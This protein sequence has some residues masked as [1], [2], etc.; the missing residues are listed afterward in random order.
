MPRRETP[1]RMSTAMERAVS[2]QEHNSGIEQTY[3]SEAQRKAALDADPWALVVE[4]TQV[5]CRGCRLHVQLNRRS[6][7]EPNLWHKHRDRCQGVKFG[8]TQLE[9]VSAGPLANES[10][11]THSPEEQKPGIYSAGAE[12][13][14]ELQ[15]CKRRGN[16]LEIGRNARKTVT[17]NLLSVNCRMRP[18]IT[19]ATAQ[20]ADTTRI[21]VDQSVRPSHLNIAGKTGRYS[22][23][24]CSPLG[25]QAAIVTPALAMRRRS[26]YNQAH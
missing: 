24:C 14:S 15:M 13:T 1:E 26:S 4:P 11:F 5:I 18:T 8:S 7:Y 3:Q 12:L 9:E 10:N 22:R 17:A 2:L 19:H 25:Y 16:R 20:V 6:S 23:F 21:A